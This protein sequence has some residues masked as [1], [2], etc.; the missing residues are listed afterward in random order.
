M[1]AWDDLGRLFPGDAGIEAAVPLLRRHWELV[2]GASEAG[3]LTAVE[4]AEAVRRQYAESLEVLRLVEAVRDPAAPPA[5]YADVG[6]GGGWPGLVIACARPGWE[7]HLVEPLQK[8]ARFLERAAAE[9]GLARVRVYGER[10]EAAGRGPLRE[11]CD[12]VTARAVAEVRVVLEYTAPLAA[13][14]GLVALPKGSRLEEELAEAGVAMGRLGCE[15]AGAP[16]MRAEVNAAVR[17]AMF[18]KT[19]PCPDAFPR[20]A[21]MP[22]KRPL[23]G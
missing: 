7:V 5:V 9:L 14:G 15:L 21:G 23:G 12:V 17:V 8:R 19:A 22:E 4:D 10:A 20:R 2:R 11:R 16:A 1:F 3:R 18:R 6:P 13:I